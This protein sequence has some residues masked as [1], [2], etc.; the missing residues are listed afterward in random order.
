[1][2]TK[3]N[4]IHYS[5]FALLIGMMPTY[6][7]AGLRVSNYSRGYQSNA[8][9]NPVINTVQQQTVTTPS[10]DTENNLPVRVAD[11]TV[12]EQIKSGS[13]DAPVAFNQ[14]EQC[15][16]IYPN[17]EFEWAAPTLGAG[18]GGADTCV[19]V[20][21]L[22]GYQAAADGS[23]LVLARAKLA[24]GDTIKCNISSFPEATM[25]VQAVE[26]FTFPADSAP[27]TDDVV[28]QLNQEQKQNAGL[29]IAAGAVIGAIGGNIAGSNDRGKDN[30]FGTDKG[31]IQGSIIGSL[32]GAAVM[33]G[34]SYAGKVAGDVI[35]S[36]G[37][38]AAA[39]GLV[40]NMAG[41]GDDV[42]RI[43]ECELPDKGKTS[44]LWGA[45]VTSTPLEPDKAHAFY[46]ID[47]DEVY[48][49]D[50]NDTNCNKTADLV[51]IVLEA[52]PKLSIEAVTNQNFEN[53]K[54][55]PTKQYYMAIESNGISFVSATDTSNKNVDGSKGIFTK[56]LSAGRIDRKIPAMIQMNDKAF[57]IN[58]SEWYEWKSRNGK[59]ITIYGRSNDGSGYTLPSTTK[60]DI[61]NFYP[62]MVGAEDG[63]LI[64]LGNKARL[65]STLIGA[66]VGGALGGFS[67]YQG[68]QS[69]IQNRWVTAVREYEDSLN[70]VYCATGNRYL[71]KYN[72]PVYIPSLEAVTE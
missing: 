55:D 36:T 19:S 29:K 28:K 8:Y 54:S 4:I 41:T 17:G 46:N 69:D 24:A 1:M 39:G 5:L 43:E 49:C 38:N 18:I 71:S 15:S 21:E 72:D 27:T 47:T 22:R 37:V 20:V 6:S 26:S 57:G 42:L 25:I 56:I 58:K 44:C 45:L 16:M 3:R 48:L 52:Y 33:A 2:K 30:L 70:K 10:T 65:K 35:L 11:E 12:V 31:K 66:G 51:S 62:M 63:A 50:G 61:N 9:Q 32:T 34:N 68:A 13:T 59:G 53:I 64:D 14:L 23:D 40:G 60:A 67:A 7:N